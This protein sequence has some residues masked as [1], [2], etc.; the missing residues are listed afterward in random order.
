MP[1]LGMLKFIT[2]IAYINKAIS[3]LYLVQGNQ[4]KAS[5]YHS[6]FK[7]PILSL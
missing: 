4:R 3:Q 6:L 5:R 7:T 1:Q 2:L